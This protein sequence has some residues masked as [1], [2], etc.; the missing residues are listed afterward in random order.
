[1]LQRYHEKNID[2]R[3]AILQINPSE[4][5]S[6]LLQEAL[7]TYH[8]LLNFDFNKV[9]RTDKKTKDLLDESA[10]KFNKIKE[11]FKQSNFKV[12]KAIKEEFENMDI[13]SLYK[14]VTSK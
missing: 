2:V 1:L 7:S 8:S 4:E 6:R 9:G 14:T 10:I 11:N 3:L 5:N 12:G 13:Q